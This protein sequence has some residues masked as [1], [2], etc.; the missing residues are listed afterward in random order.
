MEHGQE[1]GI[2]NRFGEQMPRTQFSLDAAKGGG[3]ARLGLYGTMQQN[4]AS[5]MNLIPA[6]FPS[7]PKP[8]HCAFTTCLQFLVCGGPSSRRNRA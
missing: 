4:K 1:A 5:G 8:H 2:V 3:Q 6:S 7:L